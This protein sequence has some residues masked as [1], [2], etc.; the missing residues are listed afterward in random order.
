MHGRQQPHGA[1][2]PFSV[3]LSQGPTPGSLQSRLALFE[4][5]DEG[6]P[7]PDGTVPGTPGSWYWRAPETRAKEA[8][9]VAANSNSSMPTLEADV[10]AWGRCTAFLASRGAYKESEAKGFAALR[11]LQSNDLNNPASEC[12]TGSCAAYASSTGR[13]ALSVLACDLGSV[14]LPRFKAPSGFVARSGLF[15]PSSLAL[16]TL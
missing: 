15:A 1:V 8:G 16:V 5:I 10:Y 12:F 2:S 9:L 7:V 6:G 4:I 14:G 11:A 3:V 13:G